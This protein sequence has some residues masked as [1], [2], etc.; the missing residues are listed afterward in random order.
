MAGPDA[1]FWQARF[2][3]GTIPW[4]RGAASPQLVQ[5]LEA[6]AVAPGSTVLVP[7][8]GSGWEVAAL[9]AAGAD[10]TGI[11]YT[12]AAVA[13]TRALIAAQHLRA[14]VQE[15]DVLHWSPAAPV[16]AIYEQT[17][18]CALH[19]DHWTAYAA[20]LHT[21]LRPG[22]RLLALFMQM[23]APGAAD[24]FV[25]GPPYHCDNHALRALFPAPQWTWPKPPYARVPHPNGAAELAVVL[26]RV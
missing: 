18:L 23:Q 20:Q 16:D 7:G 12:A 3:A 11:D 13:R 26:V 8:C 1:A 22:G 5:W 19:P 14:D 6:G 21:W 17:C 10:V 25:T 9:A 2:D 24:G 4:D 15:A